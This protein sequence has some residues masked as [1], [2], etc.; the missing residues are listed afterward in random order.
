MTIRKDA[1]APAIRFPTP[2]PGAGYYLGQVVEADYECTDVG[3]GVATCEGTTADGAAIDTA[4]LGEK[5]YDVTGT[6]QAGNA[7]TFTR[8]YNVVNRGEVIITTV[9]GGGPIDSVPA[10]AAPVGNPTSVA[11]DAGGRRYIVS[12]H[13]ILQVDASG[14]LTA[15]AGRDSA[16]NSGDGGPAR[17]AALHFPKG[18]AVDSSGRVYIA[19]AQNNRIRRVDPATGLITTVAGGGVGGDGS[20][21]IN[22][23][24]SAPYGVVVD[25]LGNLLIADA[26]N[27]RIRKVAAATGVISTLAG[28]GARG[29]SGDD[30]SASLAQFDSPAALAVGPDSD[31]Y[32]LDQYN[33]RVRRIDAATGIITT[34]AGNGTTGFGGDGGFATEAPL[35]AYSNSIAVDANGH[36]YIADRAN[37]RIRRVDALTGVI[38]TFAGTGVGSFG[39]DGGPATAAMLDDPDGVA[40]DLAGNVHIADTNSRRI[41]VAGAT[42]GT[43]NTSVGNGTYSL[44]AEPG[45]ATRAGISGAGRISV[46]PNGDVYLS[47]LAENRIRRIATNTGQISTVA[48]NGQL[49]FQGDGGPAASAWLNMS[50]GTSGGTALDAVGNLFIAD[51]G[52]GRIRFVDAATGV[53]STFAAGLGEPID[54]AVDAAG[55]AF[56]VDQRNHVVY[57]VDGQT[58]AVT[59][60][61]G[62]GSA[63]FGGDEGPATAASLNTPMSIAV[64]ADGAV[65]IAD[66][67]NNRV[68]RVDPVTNVITTVAGNGSS[69]STGDGGPAT[70]AGVRPWSVAV[71]SA[72]NLLIGDRSGHRVRRVD[73]HTQDITTLAGTG[74]AGFGGDGG[75]PAIAR[76]DGGSYLIDVTVSAA[77]EVY[78]YDSNARVRRVGPAGGYV[79]ATP[80]SVVANVFGTVGTNDWYTSDVSVTW[81]VTDPDRRLSSRLAATHS[82]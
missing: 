77:G 41:R 12:G 79:D 10:L 51:T 20:L 54:V 58:R 24:L 74:T 38:T 44:D 15:F 72:G 49:G 21:A 80:P 35:G 28:T 40:V 46:A 27:H 32:V 64:G 42:S 1:S 4:T 14:E 59:I 26:G 25:A 61:A 50:G 36:L 66:A 11:V 8:T 16:G 34:V 71:D 68:R 43:I 6:D 69:G 2:P 13:R 78:L 5:T 76:L 62:N 60:V 53:I 23:S 48:G 33:Q 7:Q 31:V 29:F 30:G 9:A 70:S 19:D 67:R 73:A 81:T 22:A 63:G 3:A 82:R 45:L 39:G 57:R 55:N 18:L 17:E 75:S 37:N 47:H 65:F 52:N 56:V